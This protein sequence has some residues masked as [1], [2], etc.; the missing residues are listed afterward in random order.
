MFQRNF[1]EKIK[2][3]FVTKIVSSENRDASDIM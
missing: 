1:L 2:A 3:H